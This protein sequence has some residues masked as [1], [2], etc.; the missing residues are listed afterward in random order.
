M[1]I[2][3]KINS[4]LI[5]TIAWI[6]NDGKSY[7]SKNAKTRKEN[8]MKLSELK[9]N[10]VNPEICE[11]GL[12][13]RIN[14]SQILFLNFL[15]YGVGLT[16][17]LIFITGMLRMPEELVSIAGAIGFYFNGT[18]YAL[19]L[20]TGFAES[21]LRKYR[22]RTKNGAIEDFKINRRADPQIYDLILGVVI[23]ILFYFFLMSV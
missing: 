19:G 2:K 15:Y 13:R 5:Y 21:D 12:K 11:E 3:N 22:K 4:D 7:F 8:R 17:L 16:A 18:A 10:I 9:L 20:R 23:S 6:M 14:A 1:Q